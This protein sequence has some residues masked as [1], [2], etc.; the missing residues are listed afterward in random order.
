MLVV[1]SD[2]LSLVKQRVYNYFI[3]VLNGSAAAPL[4]VL[5]PGLRSEVSECLDVMAHLLPPPS[6]D[7]HVD[8]LCQAAQGWKHDLSEMTG[9][10][11][12]RR[13]EVR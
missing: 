12:G 9:T 8:E 5:N 1:W 4:C 10:A 13:L 7:R 6:C 2:A 11:K 3:G